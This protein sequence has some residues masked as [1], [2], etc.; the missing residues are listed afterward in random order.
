MPCVGKSVVF[1]KAVGFSMMNL[2]FYL[3]QMDMAFSFTLKE[4]DRDCLEM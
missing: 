1:F 3:I 4:T 2:V